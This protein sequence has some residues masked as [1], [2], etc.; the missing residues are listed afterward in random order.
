[1]LAIGF[2]LRRAS[3]AA[4]VALGAGVIFLTVV[5]LR[6]MWR[7][8]RAS[9]DLERQIAAR[10]EQLQHEIAER[11][12][13][14]TA[15]RESQALYRSLV[16]QM[17]AGMFRKDRD[18]R[19]NFVNHWFCEYKRVAPSHFLG[20]TPAEIAAA[21]L[22]E[23]EFDTPEVTGLTPQAELHHETIMRTGKILDGEES[24]HAAD[25]SLLYYHFVK[26]PVFGADGAV[27]GSQGLLFDI[28]Q[29]KRAEAERDKLHRQL[30]DMS[31][32]AGMAEIATGVLHNVGNVLNTV[33]VSVSLVAD[34]VKN[35][36]AAKLMLA[37]ELL[38]EHKHDL[39]EFLTHDPRGTAI[40]K[41]LR[42]LAEATAKEQ[43]RTMVELQNLRQS[44]EHMKQ[45]VAMQQSYAKVGGVTEPVTLVEVVEEALRIEAR[46]FAHHDIELVRSFVAKPTL[47]TDRYKVI[48]IL[49]NLIT[50]AKHACVQHAKER[51][52]IEI[53]LTEDERAVQVAVIDNGMG[54]AA[55]NRARI[56]SHGF[57][58][59][60]DGHGFGLH[61]AALA[62]KELG[63]QCVAASD[64][65]GQG[66][67]FTLE[68][69]RPVAA[70]APAAA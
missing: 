31:R 43:E 6:L 52:R 40:P 32:Q 33:N 38:E 20:K 26:A 47:M 64:G 66:A 7:N 67:T 16:D 68:L 37:V 24:Y 58:T 5:A 8:A 36:K 53:R 3:T 18:G 46:S 48:Q 27:I 60:K 41:F 62:A 25:G 50:N 15:L 17:P 45:I 22:P 42:V 9:R 29:H 30:I 55:E 70:A 28:T 39:A 35:G 61:S 51:K 10:T 11:E 21:A 2:G 4:E 49:L 14:E 65:P 19:Y 13:A 44:I 56:F 23:R 12:K 59:R 57:T 1:M 54:I 69:P 63:G 34:A